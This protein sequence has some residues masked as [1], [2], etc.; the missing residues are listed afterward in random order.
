[1]VNSPEL[2]LKQLCV[3]RSGR[4]VFT[5]LNA[6]VTAG[7]V[8]ILKGKNGSGKSTLLRLLAGFL[9]ASD[10]EIHWQGENALA[11]KELLTVD[12]IYL[13]HAFALKNN[14]TLYE[15]LISW[16]DITLGYRLDENSV[17]KAAEAFNMGELLHEPVQYF[18]SGQRHRAGLIRFALSGKIIWLM[19]EPTVGLDAESRIVLDGLIQGHIDTGGIV[20]AATHDPLGVEGSILD[21]S[22]FTPAARDS[23]HHHD[24]DWWSEA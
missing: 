1:M 15:N 24:Q 17:M 9:P 21:M 10:G 16:G 23:I 3:K 6:S 12:L 4:M 20:I 18:S 19:D 5:G 14:F 2:H 13:G 7:E 22:H 11:D 8:L